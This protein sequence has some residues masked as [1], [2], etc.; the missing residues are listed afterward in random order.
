MCLF[1]FSVFEFQVQR[2]SKSRKFEWKEKETCDHEVNGH[3]IM[4]LLVVKYISI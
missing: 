2:S 4:F 3:W 1:V